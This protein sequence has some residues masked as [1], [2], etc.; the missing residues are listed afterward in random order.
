MRSVVVVLPASMWAMMPML[1][2]RAKSVAISSY[3]LS[4]V[5]IQPPVFASRKKLLATGPLLTAHS[6][7]IMCES[8]VCFRHTVDVV[9]FLH[10]GALALRRIAKLV[11]EL[12]GHRTTVAGPRAGDQPAHG[13]R[14]APVALDLYR[15]LVGRAT[16]PPR[17]HLE[18]RRHVAQRDF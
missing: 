15:H 7:P 17:L 1:R 3:Q 10:R 4:V 14:V 9:S 5:S 11:R 13:Q 16:H 6:P 18:D 8:L 2:V 12:L